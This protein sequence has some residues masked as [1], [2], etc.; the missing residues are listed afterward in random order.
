MIVDRVNFN[1]G[2]VSKMSREDFIAKHI[3]VFWQDRDEQ[4]R[5]KMLEDVYDRISGTKS[6][7]QKN[8][9]K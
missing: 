2:L 7:K 8:K 1:E 5:R 3:G 9:E 4:T 6:K